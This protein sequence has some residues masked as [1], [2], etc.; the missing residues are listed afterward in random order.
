MQVI[1]AWAQL[2]QGPEQLPPGVSEVFRRA[3]TSDE[4]LEGVDPDEVALE[5]DLLGIDR[6]CICGWHS[7]GGPLISNDQVA[8]VVKRHPNRFVGIASVDLERPMAAQAELE[9]AVSE[10]GFRGLRVV[11]WLWNRPPTDRLYY[12]LFAKCVELGIPFCT[13]VGHTWPRHPSEPGRPIPYLDQV[14]L[15]FPDL[16]IVAGHVG[17]PWTDEMIA[18]ARKHANVFIDTSA[19][20]PR[21][22]PESLKQFIRAGG[23][24]K[25]LFATNYPQ[26]RL[27]RCIREAHELNLADGVAELFFGGNANRVFGLS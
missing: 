17:Y 13:Q 11:P 21:R 6:L 7:P 26:M 14:A 2:P 19:W 10:L 23:R 1:D 8:G 16:T 22:L 3:G 12:P 9:R 27:D 20:A 18:V 5:M 24:E 25:V 15:D 4:Y